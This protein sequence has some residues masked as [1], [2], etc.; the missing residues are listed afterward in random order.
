MGLWDLFH[1]KKADEMPEEMPEAIRERRE[2]E[3]RGAEHELIRQCETAIEAAREMEN[4]K[5]EYQV[6]TASLTD[7]QKIDNLPPGQRQE[8]NTLADH[9]VSLKREMNTLKAGK[10]KLSDVQFDRIRKY[11]Q[12]IPD[13]IGR[14]KNNETYQS[15]VKRDMQYL[16]GE[17]GELSYRITQIEQEQDKLKKL[18]MAAMALFVLG[19]VILFVLQE[20]Y[21]MDM[22]AGFLAILLL[23]AGAGA[24]IVLR[25]QGNSREVLQ[26]R[27]GVNRAITLLNRV[28][29]RYVNETNAVEY[30]Y[31]KYGVHSAYEL[32]YLWEQYQEA[33]RERERFYRATDDLEYYE[34]K[35]VQELAKYDIEDAMIWIHQT[36]ALIDDREMV[37]IRHGLN[38]RRQKLRSR[39]EYNAKVIREFQEEV[40]GFIKE[41]PG[42]SGEL[43]EILRAIGNL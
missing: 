4:A 21:R 3:R 40:A 30:A 11:E 14:M 8:I 10:E 9:V 27:A 36:V 38:T 7:I 22:R 2:P 32:G 43:R 6:V 1:R 20:K 39:I 42:N 26:A 25:L 37:E 17:K 34:K 19:L 33:R 29:I 23:S 13:A 12:E 18:S 31:E 16:E 41:N 15:T 28:K 5:L 24:F 35:L